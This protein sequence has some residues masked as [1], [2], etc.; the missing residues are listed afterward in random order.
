MGRLGEQRTRLVFKSILPGSPMPMDLVLDVKSFLIEDKIVS[1]SSSCVVGV[2][3]FIFLVIKKA[4][5]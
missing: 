1:N 3:T 2:L 5:F 4:C